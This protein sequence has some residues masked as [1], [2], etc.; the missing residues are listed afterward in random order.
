MKMRQYPYF[1]LFSKAIRQF[2]QL[3]MCFVRVVNLKLFFVLICT[4]VEQ[5]HVA[6]ITKRMN[7]HCFALEIMKICLLFFWLYHQYLWAISAS[8]N[9][10]FELFATHYFKNFT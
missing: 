7:Q 3:F 9:N 10:Y 1:L 4:L 5:F 6:N 2:V 8:L